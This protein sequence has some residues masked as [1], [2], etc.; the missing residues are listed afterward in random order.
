MLAIEHFEE[1]TVR[2]VALTLVA[3]NVAVGW[4]L[5][6]GP[7]AADPIPDPIHESV[8]PIPISE[9]YTVALN[10]PGEVKPSVTVCQ[11]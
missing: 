6:A 11:P 2:V 8:R 4:S 9:C 1:D 7:A 3:V 5:A 10:P